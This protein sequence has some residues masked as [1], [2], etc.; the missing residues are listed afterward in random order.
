[1]QRSRGKKGQSLVEYAIGIG[2]VSAVC[3]VALSFLGHLSGDIFY[4]VQSAVNYDGGPG[5]HGV[6]SPGR[7]VN[8]DQTPWVLD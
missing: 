3:M 1:M 7:L 2:C 8:K 6:T 5:A 4:N